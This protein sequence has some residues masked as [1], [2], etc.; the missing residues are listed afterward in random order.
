MGRIPL[1]PL[2]IKHTVATL[3][4]SDRLGALQRDLAIAVTAKIVD[5]WAVGGCVVA[6]VGA[7][8]GGC[9]DRWCLVT[10]RHCDVSLW[11]CRKVV[12]R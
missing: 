2:L 11:G 7:G 4:A 3:L 5:R 6:G 10:G 1:G 9:A 8:D 12:R